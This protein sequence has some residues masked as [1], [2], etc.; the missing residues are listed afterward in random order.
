MQSPTQPTHTHK[1]TTEIHR[2]IP[3]TNYPGLSHVILREKTTT[4]PVAFA[5]VPAAA[6]VG[7]NDSRVFF[8]VS[9]GCSVCGVD[10]LSGESGR[11]YVGPRRSDV[12]S[13]CARF[14]LIIFHTLSTLVYKYTGFW[15]GAKE[16]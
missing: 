14:E 6:A 4:T 15:A 2:Q 13:A 5:A 7:E 12:R 10:W 1:K 9:L 3:Y 8:A 11:M 16:L